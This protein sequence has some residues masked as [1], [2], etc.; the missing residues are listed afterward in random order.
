MVCK[1]WYG[2]VHWDSGDNSMVGGGLVRD[3]MAKYI[4]TVEIIVW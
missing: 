1:R 4:G 3:G 2:E